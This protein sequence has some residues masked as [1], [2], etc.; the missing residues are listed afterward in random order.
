MRDIMHAA[1]V[2]ELEKIAITR[3][4]IIEEAQSGAAGFIPNEKIWKTAPDLAKK[5]N[6]PRQGPGV[7]F[8]PGAEDIKRY[9]LHPEKV[10]ELRR[11]EM[12]HWKRYQ[13]GKLNVRPGLRGV[14]HLIREEIAANRSAMKRVPPEA[15]AAFRKS[16]PLNV[17]DS[18]TRYY[19]GAGHEAYKKYQKLKAGPVGKAA[20]GLKT[21]ARALLRN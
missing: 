14:P 15:R 20:R 16:I 1:L 13:Q 3:P 5:H 8:L 18:T 7:V 9:N 6:I 19:S 11:H 17:V 2:D 10:K 21:V 12:T 4:T